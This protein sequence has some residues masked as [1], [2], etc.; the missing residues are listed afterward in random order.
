MNTY[1]VTRWVTQPVIVVKADSYDFESGF[2]N[3][4]IG[5]QKIYSVQGNNVTTIQKN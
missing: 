2:V 5:T 1:I 4:Y 3:F